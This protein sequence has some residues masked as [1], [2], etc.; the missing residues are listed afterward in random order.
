MKNISNNKDKQKIINKKTRRIG[1]AKGLWP[2]TADDIF[3]EVDA[4]SILLE[5]A[6]KKEID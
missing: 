6:N 5:S 4:G 3:D 2:E 1:I